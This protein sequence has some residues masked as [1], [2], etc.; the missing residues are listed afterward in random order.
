MCTPQL[1]HDRSEGWCWYVVSEKQANVGV[2]VF[3]VILPARSR[4]RPWLRVMAFTH[5][6]GKLVRCLRWWLAEYCVLPKGTMLGE[7]ERSWSCALLFPYW[8][9]TTQKDP[10]HLPSTHAI[11]NVHPVELQQRTT[12]ASRGIRSYLTFPYAGLR[13]RRRIQACSSLEAVP[14]FRRRFDHPH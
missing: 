13:Y 9:G 4:R 10:H 5:A 1:F 2:E 7:V 11:A 14:C 8:E 12:V 3:E 6:M